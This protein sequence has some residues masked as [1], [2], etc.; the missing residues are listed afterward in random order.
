MNIR[1]YCSDASDDIY[2]KAMIITIFGLPETIT[3]KTIERQ[4]KIYGE[5]QTENTL[6]D[7]GRN[8]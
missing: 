8:V 4:E 7:T 1:C 5:L 6:L 3:L 2:K